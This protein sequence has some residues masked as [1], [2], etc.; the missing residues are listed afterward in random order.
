[1]EAMESQGLEG[2]NGNGILR[3]CECGGAVKGRD[4]GVLRWALT[5]VDEL[6]CL[7]WAVLPVPGAGSGQK[8]PCWGTRYS[9]ASTRSPMSSSSSSER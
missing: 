2:S 7:R 8:N 4:P 1:M 3:K 9:S 5:L 6:R